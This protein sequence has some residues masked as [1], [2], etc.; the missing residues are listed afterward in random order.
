MKAE[1]LNKLSRE[2]RE[3]IIRIEARLNEIQIEKT[4]IDNMLINLD[5][6]GLLMD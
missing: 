1:I 6:G 2:A 3:E 5:K 4:E